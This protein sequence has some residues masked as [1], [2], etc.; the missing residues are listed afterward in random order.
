MEAISYCC[1]DVY[2]RFCRSLLSA[3][4]SEFNYHAY[5][6]TIHINFLHIFFGEKSFG[7]CEGES[8]ISNVPEEK[9]KAIDIEAWGF[10]WW[11][12]LRWSKCS[13]HCDLVNIINSLRTALGLNHIV[14]Y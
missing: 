5:K 8:K 3:S 2:L 10:W 13:S 9:F 11:G 14:N 12:T 7:L 1:K 4:Y 6:Y